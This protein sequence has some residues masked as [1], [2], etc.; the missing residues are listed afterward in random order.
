M[1]FSEWLFNEMQAREWTAVEAAKQ[2]GVDQSLVSRYVN[3]GRVPSRRTAKK[4]AATFDVPLPALLGMIDE[5]DKANAVADAPPADVIAFGMPNGFA[6]MLWER[7]SQAA[8]DRIIESVRIEV[9]EAV[10][11]GEI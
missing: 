11:R 9:E 7:L 8:K 6:D 5:Q 2:L 3:G 1:L 10:E 4:I